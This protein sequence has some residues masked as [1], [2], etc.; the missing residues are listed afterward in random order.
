MAQYTDLKVF[1]ALYDFMLEVYKNPKLN[2]LPRDTKYTLL[3]DI[4]KD[5]P[6]ILGFIFCANSSVEDKCYYIQQARIKVECIRI[7]F[8]LLYALH[9]LER[10]SYFYFAELVENLSKQLAGWQKYAQE[11]AKRKG[12][13][14]ED[15]LSDSYAN[16]P[17]NN[18]IKGKIERLNTDIEI[19]L[20]KR[21]EYP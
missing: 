8:R 14:K 1:K 11:Y 2:N 5:G 12:F 21:I 15:S 4:R 9:H 7:N 19:E 13:N 18:R 20:D 10:K 17:A 3:Q 6:A 16:N